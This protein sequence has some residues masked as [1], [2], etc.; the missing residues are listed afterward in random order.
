MVVEG[1]K[2]H[3][4]LHS[5]TLSRHLIIRLGH[6]ALPFVRRQPKQLSDARLRTASLYTSFQRYNRPGQRAG[7]L[8]LRGGFP[9]SSKRQL[10]PHIFKHNFRIS[11]IGRLAQRRK[12]IASQHKDN[13]VISMFLTTRYRVRIA[14]ASMPQGRQTPVVQKG[15]SERIRAR[16]SGDPIHYWC[17]NNTSIH[18]HR[19]MF[20]L[21]SHLNAL[22]C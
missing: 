13:M 21:H 4:A 10:C 16:Q 7:L 22:F 20:M 11:L 19:F 3:L 8:K 9:P 15:E 17:G 2:W 18:M 6:Q 1:N 5:Y 14:S 12:D